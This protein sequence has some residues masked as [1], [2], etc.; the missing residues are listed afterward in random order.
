MGSSPFDMG[1]L[2]SISRPVELVV[3]LRDSNTDVVPPRIPSN[4]GYLLHD[5]VGALDVVDDE[6]I[7]LG[8]MD[9]VGTRVLRRLC[10]ALL[11][12]RLGLGQSGHD[13]L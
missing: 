10:L 9:C 13:R 2:P 1:P 6:R 8:S 12:F 4:A 5:L 3:L 11:A 7:R